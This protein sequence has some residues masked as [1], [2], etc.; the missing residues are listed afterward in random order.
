M[1]SRP[2]RLAF[3]M[4]VGCI[5]LTTTACESDE[6]KATNTATEFAA[7][8]ALGLTESAAPLV[9]EADRKAIEANSENDEDVPIDI[10]A[11][12]Q[13]VLEK[14]DDQISVEI[15]ELTTEG[16]TMFADVT[17]E[18][19]DPDEILEVVITAVQTG[20]S[21]DDKGENTDSIKEKLAGFLENRDMENITTERRIEL[22]KEGGKW[23]VF[24]DYETSFAVQSTIEEAETLAGES[25]YDQAHEKLEEAR[26]TIADKNFPRLDEEIDTLEASYL[27][28]EVQGYGFDG[29]EDEML[30]RY[31]MMVDEGH[32]ENLSS[33]S[34]DNLN[35]KLEELREKKASAEAKEA[36]IELIELANV[37]LE[38]SYMGD[39]IEGEVTNNGDKEIDLLI[40]AAKLLDSE[41]NEVD[42]RT[43]S[44]M[45]YGEKAD[46]FKPGDTEEFSISVGNVEGWE[47]FDLRIDE[48]DFLEDR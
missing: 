37:E 8:D 48:L 39:T 31:E 21:S 6:E 3:I 29:R 28:R 13:T 44:L 34:R 38:S 12:E 10:A 5:F 19:P 43:D 18:A 24:A 11:L 14:V 1:L 27:Y 30:E 41:G 16:D 15:G 7:M 4:L 17:V 32:V 33:G 22:R 23:L 40:I 36:Y 20:S 2:K 47:E 42:E 26:E 9:T 46:Q 25:E 45:A 35:E